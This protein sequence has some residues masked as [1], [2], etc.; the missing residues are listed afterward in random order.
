M[1]PQEKARQLRPLIT[2]AAKS[3]DDGDALNAVELFPTWR[4][5]AEYA[6]DDRV[7]YGEKLYRCVQAHTSQDGWEPPNVPAL[8]MEVAKPGEIPVWRQPTGAQD[9]YSKGDRVHYPTVD[10]PVYESTIDNN[11]WSPADYP[12]GWKQI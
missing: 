1:T 7:R 8:W 6:T 5:V 9:A 4:T 11:V 10:D 2:K 3:L 12:A